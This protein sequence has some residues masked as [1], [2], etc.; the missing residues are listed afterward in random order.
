MSD[1]VPGANPVDGELQEVVTW[2][3][4]ERSDRGASG[5]GAMTA[6]HIVY[7]KLHGT[8]LQHNINLG[9]HL[10]LNKVKS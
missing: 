4:R 10:P 5:V 2:E 7:K 8:K 3:S 1:Y 6:Y 9:Q